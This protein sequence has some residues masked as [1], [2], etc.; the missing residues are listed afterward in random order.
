VWQYRHTTP[1]AG[2]IR[3]RLANG[4]TTQLITQGDTGWRVVRKSKDGN[5][6]QHG[7]PIDS[8]K[9]T[10][11]YVIASQIITELGHAGSVLVVATT[12]TQAQQLAQGLAQACDE[13][14]ALTPLVDFVRQQ[15]GDNHPL[16]AVLRCGVGFH[17]A[18]LPIEVLEALEEAVRDD[19]LPYLTCTSTLTDGVNLPVRTVVIYDQTYSG[20]PEDSRLRGARLVNAMGRAGRA[21]KE[22][23]GWI[24]LVRAAAP[25][26]Q[27]FQDLNPDAEALAVTSSLTTESA[28]ASFAALETALRASEDSI[29]TASGEAADFIGFVWLILAIEETRNVDPSDIDI[30]DIVGATLAATQSQDLRARC[31]VIAERTRQL[32]VRTDPEAR[33]RWSR[34]GTTIGSARVIDYLARQLAVEVIR[35]ESVGQTP[36]LSSPAVAI[37]WLSN[38][39]TL[40]LD[41]TE[42]PQWQFRVSRQGADIQVSPVLLL[43]DWIA[44]GSLPYL[45][46]TYLHAA[47]SAAW[48]IEQMVGAVTEHFEHYLAWTVG[49]LVEL[50]NAHLSTVETETR[51]CVELG[52]YIR[53]GVDTPHALVLM[54]SGIR[55]RRLVHAIITDLPSEI[56]PVREVLRSWLARMTISHWRTHYAASASEVL[57]L[58]DFT[59]LRNRS[60]LRTLLEA[61]VVEL[62]IPMLS[63]PHTP[64]Q[65]LTLGPVH[66]EPEPEPLALYADG[67]VIGTVSP[68]DHADTVAILDTGL[69]VALQLDT[70]TTPAS[71]R[72]SLAVGDEAR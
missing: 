10:K 40:L 18:G 6:Q 48:R 32:Y 54:T 50:V 45:A 66:G 64:E 57:D 14:P 38:A 41:L 1:L 7:L 22:T 60:L 2:V 68:E 11:H 49:A 13:Q 26:E 5:S 43:S 63:L 59:R 70:R 37:P 12:R 33:R 8:G 31:T 15:L 44:G 58:L 25:T 56:P 61:G 62:N 9:S 52:G 53:Y 72:I 39:L 28:L 21:G 55:S 20:Q 46:E 42:A 34:A 67:V 19:M 17:H 65:Q 35:L 71:L 69:D 36:E 4:R 16:V 29:F 23:E 24:V 51:L 3:L 47:V 27:D 30:D